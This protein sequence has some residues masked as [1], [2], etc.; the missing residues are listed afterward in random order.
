MAQ[1]QIF[2][3]NASDQPAW[4]TATYPDTTISQQILYSTANNTVGQLTTANSRIPST[5]SAGVLAMRAFTV[6]R[7]VFTSSGT[8]TPTTGMLYCVAECVGGGGGGGGAAA[9]GANE[10]AA[11]GGGGAG[12]YSSAVISA[13]TI[14]ASQAVTIGAAG[15]SAT[16]GN[17]SG[18]TGGTSSLG[19]LLTANGGTGG[20][21]SNSTLTITYAQAGQGGISSG[22]GGSILINGEFGESGLSFGTNFLAKSGAGANSKFGV[23]AVSGISQAGIS[24]NG[25]NAI[26]NGSGGSGGISL[27]NSAAAAGGSGGAGIVVITEYVIN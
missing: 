18:G 7:R 15:T 26:G 4:S 16:A 17:N 10:A 2:R 20:G 9:T 5:N 3:A 19:A 13:A 1:G 22:P 12:G 11:G 24:F 21:G 27:N 23:G 8:Y 6:N 25:Q 14:G